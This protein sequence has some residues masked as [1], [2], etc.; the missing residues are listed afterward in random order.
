M[1]EIIRIIQMREN[2]KRHCANKFF[3]KSR[4]QMKRRGQGSCIRSNQ[5]PSPPY[6]AG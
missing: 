1:D 6:E 4:S 5:L 2:P 3:S